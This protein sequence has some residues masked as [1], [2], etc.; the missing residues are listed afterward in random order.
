M[1]KIFYFFIFL[2]SVFTACTQ[3][4]VPKNKGYLRVYLPK[5]IYAIYNNPDLPFVFQKDSLAQVTLKS[6]K[7]VILPTIFYPQLNAHLYLTYYTFN[8][9][10]E[11]NHLSEYS[12]KMVYEHIAHSNGIDEKE[13]DIAGHKGIF[14]TIKGNAASNFQFYITDHTQHFLRGSFYFL[15]TPFILFSL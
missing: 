14:Y 5:P 11:V 1:N 3:T 13:I 15:A 4:N 7:K 8:S 9:S 10:E 12:R 6:D 2:F